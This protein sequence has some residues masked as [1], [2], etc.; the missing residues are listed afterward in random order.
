MITKT[1]ELFSR[2]T[3]VLY[4]NIETGIKVYKNINGYYIIWC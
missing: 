3:G 4:G 1:T 2:L